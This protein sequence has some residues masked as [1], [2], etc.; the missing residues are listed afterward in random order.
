MADVGEVGAHYNTNFKS[1]SQLTSL[2]APDEFRVSDHDPVVVG[3]DLVDDAAGFVAGGGFIQSPAGA[4]VADPA[5]AGKGAFEIDVDYEA[6]AT[7]P[8]GEFVFSLGGS[9]VPFEVTSTSFDFLA[10]RAG[11]ARFA[12]AER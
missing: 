2:Y 10:I 8:T 3:L 1:S 4:L 5:R 6:G 9:G 11:A 12:G 7:H